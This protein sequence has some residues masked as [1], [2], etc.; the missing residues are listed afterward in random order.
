MV[1][2]RYVFSFFLKSLLIMIE[3]MGVFLSD[4]IFYLV[5]SLWVFIVIIKYNNVFKCY[6]GE[7]FNIYFLI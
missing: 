5:V 2:F 3:R 4:L 7:I 6:R 1:G